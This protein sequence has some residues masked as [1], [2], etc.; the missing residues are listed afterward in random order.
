[1]PVVTAIKRRE[2]RGSALFQVFVE[3]VYRFTLSDLDLSLSGV[4]VGTE[5][6]DSQIDG[7]ENQAN[8][9][10]AY[11]LAV[12]YVGLRLRS[13]R[14]LTDYLRRKDST[15][16]E[17]E[18]ALDRLE[19]LGLVDDEKFARA[20][21]ADRMKFRVRSRMR[22]EQELAAKGIDRDIALRVL[23]DLE[24]E[25]ELTALAELIVSKSSQSAYREEKKLIGYLQRQGYRW[26]LIKE[27]LEK[28]RELS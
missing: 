24:P 6:T 5:L 26:G 11:A 23:Q 9:A 28:A 18:A 16:E 13:R 7:Y 19:G 12:R 22:L 2:R 17:I 14:E 21:V 27:A 25:D 20:W 3:G 8:E 1:M 15:P 10:K 4:R